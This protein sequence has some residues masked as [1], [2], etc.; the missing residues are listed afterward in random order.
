MDKNEGIEENERT[1]SSLIFLTILNL[2]FDRLN[3]MTGRI[4]SSGFGFG[5]SGCEI[6]RA[7]IFCGFQPY[8]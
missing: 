3:Y 7:E 8:Q 1:E 5:L 4:F 2:L 6:C